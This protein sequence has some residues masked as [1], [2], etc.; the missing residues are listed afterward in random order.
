MHVY[1]T[2][3]GNLEARTMKMMDRAIESIII[4]TTCGMVFPK[5]APKLD[6]SVVPTALANSERN[7]DPEAMKYIVKMM[8]VPK[9]IPKQP[10]HTGST[11]SL[12]S[13]GPALTK[14]NFS[15]NLLLY[16][17]NDC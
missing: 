10:K 17:Y 5:I 12:S 8:N 3:F 2:H 4:P 1:A 14:S 6:V 9:N 15:L 11:N 7:C 13:T 16:F